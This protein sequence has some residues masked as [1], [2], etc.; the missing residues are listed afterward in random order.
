MSKNLVIEQRAVIRFLMRKNRK[1]SEIHQE[2]VDV[3]Q[4]NAL[5]YSTVSRWITQ[6]RCGRESFEDDA[7]GG[8]EPTVVT[9]ETINA[10]RD[11]IKAD[12]RLKIREIAAELGISSER[13]HFILHEKLG[14]SKVCARWVPRLLTREQK[15]FREQQ[16]L[17]LFHRFEE[18]P[19][20]FRY[21]IV[22][23][24]ET[25]VHH[26]DPETKHQSMQWVE[27]GKRPPVKARVVPSAGKVMLALFW[28]SEGPVLA[29]FLPPKT[30]V[31]GQYYASLMIKL[32]DAIK[33]K[34][35]EKVKRGVML[36]HDNAPSHK[37]HV[38]QAAI[39]QCHFEELPHPPYSPDLAPSDFHVFR[40]LKSDFKGKRFSDDDQLRLAVMAWLDQM[41]LTFWREGIDACR[42]RWLKCFNAKGDYIE[43]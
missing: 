4:D 11:M 32:S 1:L 26:Y 21:R 22:T 28:D 17:I 9:D 23:G 15:E 31:T 8:N 42:E 41:P 36:L 3:Y 7:P 13:V 10:V 24:D 2:L 40:K 18:D 34:R 27:K 38:A 12:R 6:F 14:L 37:A 5:P 16:S 30:T 35:R 33:E 29:D 19:D 25:W 43:K 20:D 39:R